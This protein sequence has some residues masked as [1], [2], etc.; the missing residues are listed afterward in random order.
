VFREWLSDLS[1]RVRALARRGAVEREL[2]D[3][4]RFHIERQAEELERRGLAPDEALR[5]ARVAFGGL[6]SMKE[7]TRDAHGTVFVES[8]LQDL[9][10]ALRV[11]AK[12]PGLSLTIILILGL[13]IGANVATFTVMDALLLRALPVPHAD[14]LVVVGDPDS[15][16]SSWHG[17]PESRYASYPVYQD[18]RD[19]NHV[20]SG[21]Y[22]SGNL[23]TPDVVMRDS[24]G[25]VEHPA[26]RVV[27]GNFFEVLQVPAGVGRTILPED[28]RG[29]GQPVIVISHGYWQRRFGGDRSA[30]GR[31]IIV[32]HLTL[33]IVGVTPASFPG[34]IVGKTVDGWIP[35]AI[36]PALQPK[37]APLTDRVWSWLQ[38]MGRLKPGVTLLQARAELTAIETESIRSHATGDDLTQFD[39]DLKED[40]ITVVSGERG[41][42]RGRRTFG[43][44]L[45]ILMTAVAL[46]ILIVCANVANLMLVRG[47]ARGREMTVRM[48]LG[49]GRPRLIRQLL[50]ESLLLAAAG[51]LLGWFA[52]G[53]GSRLLLALAG[54]ARAPIPLDVSPDARVLAFTAGITLLAALVFGLAPAA[55]ATRLDVATTLREQGRTLMGARTRLGRF[56]AGKVLVIVQI[57]LSA[58]LLIGAG[59]LLRTMQR[60]FEADLGFDRAHV[61]VVQVEAQKSGFEGQHTFALMR[62]LTDRL[63]GVPSVTG[64]SVTMHGLFSGGWGNM[65]AAVPGFT[66]ATFADLEVGY[67][68]V[69]PDYF[70][71][72]GARILA[73]R[74]FDAR[75]SETGARVAIINRAAANVYFHGV[76]PIGRVLR[77][78]GDKA[79]STIVGVVDDI[80]DRSVRE[81]AGRR[82]FFPIFQQDIQPV[83]VVAAHVAGDAT[84]SVAAIRDALL[85]RNGDLVFEVQPVNDLVANSVAE[86]RLTTIVTAFFG[87]IALLLAALGLYGVTA[88]ATSQRTGEFGL[89]IALGAEPRRVTWMILN[90]STRLAALG[91]AVGIPGGLLA[92]FLIRRQLFN[93]TPID[94][95]SLALAIVVL[96]GT[97]L[98]ASYIP[99]RRAARIAPVDA[100]RQE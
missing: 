4:L 100:L 72:I 70:R 22:A 9:R 27:T 23:S 76:N 33:T 63:R 14:Q 57:A 95:P 1:Y 48:A 19:R 91:L 42:S 45:S 41:F 36:E 17:S 11:V 94:P 47:I 38:M 30:V 59:L 75:D 69:G 64:A 13:G 40:P 98:L 25:A 54:T 49:A 84:Q 96:A 88:Y 86:D 3:E 66:P 97:A 83:F 34:D 7:A 58:V 10:Y 71:T 44:A 78:E 16:G 73:G 99:A 92:T 90:E 43:P 8:L 21:L 65:H 29:G 46:V 53:A 28:D 26:L 32:N 18:L 74:D 39:S 85:A 56:A 60:L 55:R 89:R 52:A 20:L 93:V 2:D 61:V 80:H 37:A 62:E 50:T 6:E 5:Q 31:E 51:G 12:E 79:D 35:I 87:V 67:D 68:A 24:G 77:A 15:V 82:A 81:P